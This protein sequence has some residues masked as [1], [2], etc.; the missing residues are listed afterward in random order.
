[1]T[2]PPLKT[3]RV[4]RIRHLDDENAHFNRKIRLQVQIFAYMHI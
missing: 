2:H 3:D 4:T 1:M